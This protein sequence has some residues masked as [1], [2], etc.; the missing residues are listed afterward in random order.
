MRRVHMDTRRLRRA[1]A[2]NEREKGVD[3]AICKMLRRELERRQRL[4]RQRSAAR[5]RQSKV[6][7]G[8]RREAD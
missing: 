4:A 5:K 2:R 1:L 3:A 7:R 8:K 6:G